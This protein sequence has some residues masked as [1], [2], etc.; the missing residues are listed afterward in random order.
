MYASS[1]S[2]QSRLRQLT[3]WFNP[4]CERRGP[5]PPRPAPADL[6]D[7]GTLQRWLLAA[8]AQARRDGTL[9]GAVC[10]RVDNWPQLLASLGPHAAQL[11][12]A[13]AGSRLRE[14]SRQTDLA[15]YTGGSEFVLILC[16]L[17][18]RRG[19]AA[20][21][22]RLQQLF[23]TPVA[24]PATQ[25][26]LRTSVGTALFPFDAELPEDLLEAARVDGEPRRSNARL[27]LAL[28]RK[29]P[30]V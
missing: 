26:T 7:A 21:L 24:L 13:E 15:A 9:V 30:R 16:G 10:I 23:S 1:G 3:A 14:C 17:D 18:S 2:T 12:L 20:A 6:A 4:F 8:L 28:G 19:M 29:P 11:V 5:L 27:R 22:Q 25:C